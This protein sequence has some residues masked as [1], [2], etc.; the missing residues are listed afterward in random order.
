MRPDRIFI[1]GTN[2]SQ[3]NELNNLYHR[4]AVT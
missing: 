4:D 3:S 1:L 2:S